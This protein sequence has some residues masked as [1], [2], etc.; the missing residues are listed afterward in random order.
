MGVWRVGT[1]VYWPIKI[2][3]LVGFGLILFTSDTTLKMS[4]LKQEVHFSDCLYRVIKTK[5][6]KQIVC[7]GIC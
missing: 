7:V 4:L 5:F 6:K 3:E 2:A 1:M